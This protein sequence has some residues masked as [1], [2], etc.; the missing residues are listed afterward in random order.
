MSNKNCESQ[1]LTTTENQICAGGEIG[2]GSCK[3]DSGGGLFYG[4]RLVE[5]S[6][7][8]TDQEA[9]PWFLL[10]IVSYGN[11]TCGIGKP[12]VYTKVSQYVDWIKKNIV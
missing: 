12:E 9:R 1:S 5:D 4:N 8:E 2:K 6:F 10:G 3:G 7:T 11:P